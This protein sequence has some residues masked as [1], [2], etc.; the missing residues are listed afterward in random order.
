MQMPRINTAHDSILH[1]MAGFCIRVSPGIKH[2]ADS[3]LV[4]YGAGYAGEIHALETAEHQCRSRHRGA[5]VS[6][7]NNPLA[8][9]LLH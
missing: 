3:V 4:R 6:R 5:G 8:L 7:T 9:A 1:Q 2:I